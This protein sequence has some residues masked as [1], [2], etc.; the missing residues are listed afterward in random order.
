MPNI[1]EKWMDMGH[2]KGLQ[3]GRQEGRE[4]GRQEGRQEGHQENIAK[5]LRKKILTPSEIASAL[6]V[7]LAWVLEIQASLNKTS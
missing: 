7:D 1:V 3:E 2:Q 6:D 4:E 5:L